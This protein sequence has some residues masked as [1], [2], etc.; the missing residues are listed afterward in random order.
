MP[1]GAWLHGARA[2]AAGRTGRPEVA[3]QVRGVRGVGA[4]LP[5]AP[6]RQLVKGAPPPSAGAAR[7]CWEMLG[8]A[9]LGELTG[10]AAMGTAGA[11]LS[12]ADLW[13]VCWVM[14]HLHPAGD[15]RARSGGPGGVWRSDPGGAAALARGR[16]AAGD[17]ISGEVHLS[18]SGRGRVYHPVRRAGQNRIAAQC[19][20]SDV[21]MGSGD[22]QQG[23]RP[24]L[25]YTI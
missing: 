24:M 20:W 25:H 22:T 6:A 5:V 9:T 17:T 16:W 2:A 23:T 12:W 8:C 21:S 14:E 15:W 13:T 4:G 18:D 7:C 19:L 11:Q 10:C 1:T 3:R